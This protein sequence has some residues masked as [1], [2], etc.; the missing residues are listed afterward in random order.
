MPCSGTGRATRLTGTR[1]HPHPSSNRRPIRFP[2]P[3]LSPF[4][5]F[6][7]SPFPHPCKPGDTSHARITL[8]RSL[9]RRAT[10][11]PPRPPP[12]P[13]PSSPRTSSRLHVYVPSTS[14]ADGSSP[15][16]RA[17]PPYAIPSSDASTSS[18]S[19]SSPSSCSFPHGRSSM[20]RVPTGP[21]RAGRFSAVCESDAVAGSVPPS[22]HAR[23]TISDGISTK[24]WYVPV[25]RALLTSA[26]FGPHPLA[27][28]YHPPRFR[29]PPPR[30][31]RRDPR[32]ASQLPG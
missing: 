30:P 22:R 14:L 27:P 10:C 9:P 31:P 21:A 4:P 16:P 2:R 25:R 19:S 7:L 18:L 13:G 6:P 29:F 3:P 24:T 32:T 5:P 26:S 23:S 12:T 17:T 1:Q 11:P 15:P 8:L 28:G 20:S